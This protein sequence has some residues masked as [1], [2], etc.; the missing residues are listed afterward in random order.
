MEHRHAVH[1]LKTKRSTDSIARTLSRG[2]LRGKTE[3]VSTRNKK[4]NI[5]M[6][7]NG[8]KNVKKR[9]RPRANSKRKG[10]E[11]DSDGEG[12]EDG[13]RFEH[14]D[15][16]KGRVDDDFEELQNDRI[17]KEKRPKRR[18]FG[19]KTHPRRVELL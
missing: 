15:G 11:S 19:N 18:I 1:G 4:M 17:L 5:M 16:T 12:D 3:M 7:G 9:P 13:T 14:G 2:A 10:L 8:H 6:R